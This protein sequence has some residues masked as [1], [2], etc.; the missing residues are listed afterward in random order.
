[1]NPRLPNPWQLCGKIEWE[2]QVYEVRSRIV[3]VDDF[4]SRK[5]FMLVFPDGKKR[6][7]VLSVTKTA[8]ED[9]EAQFGLGSHDAIIRQ[10]VLDEA[11]KEIKATAK[12]VSLP[13][14]G[15]NVKLV[16]LDMEPPVIHGVDFAKIELEMMAS[17]SAK[18]ALPGEH[19]YG[20]PFPPATYN[21]LKVKAVMEQ[22]FQEMA[23]K[24]AMKPI[25]PAYFGHGT[26]VLDLPAGVSKEEAFKVFYGGPP[27]SKPQVTEKGLAT[28]KRYGA[29]LVG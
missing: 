25:D 21:A 10:T 12:V 3:I 9:Y 7:L 16:P 15:P 1:M 5:R 13:L 22:Y 29:A 26:L 19:V 14:A 8:I 4:L 2:E 28:L 18:E 24:Y 11:L 20:K 6:M 17:I 23:A 27:E